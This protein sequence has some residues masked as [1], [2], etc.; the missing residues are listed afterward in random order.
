MTTKV[1]KKFP[2]NAVIDR[3][4]ERTRKVLQLDEETLDGVRGG[5]A[6]YGLPPT[7]HWPPTDSDL[8]K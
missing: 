5:N 8:K 4:H 1:E 2:R 7:P 3:Q 6:I